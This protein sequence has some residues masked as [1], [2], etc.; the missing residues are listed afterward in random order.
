MTQD[1]LSPK[2]SGRFTRTYDGFWDGTFRV[3]YSN[4]PAWVMYDLLTAK[5][6][7]LG[8]KIETSQVDKWALY[9]VAQYCD[10]MVDNGMGGMEPRF[11]CNAYLTE[12]RQAYEVLQD[13][14]SCFRGMY[15]WD[16]QNVSVN[17][18]RTSDPVAMYTNSNVVE[19][20]FSYSSSP[21]NTISTAVQIQYVDAADGYRTKSEYVSDDV[22][23]KRYGLNVKQIT[24]FGCT[25]RSQAIRTGKWLLETS[26]LERQSV[27]FSVGRAG[28]KHLPYDIIQVVDNDYVGVDMEGRIESVNQYAVTLDREISDITGTEFSYLGTDGNMHRSNIITKVTPTTLRLEEVIVPHANSTF[29]IRSK[30]LGKRFFRAMSISEDKDAGTYTISAI[31]HVPE[32]E[33]IVDNGAVFDPQKNTIYD[34]LPIINGTQIQQDSGGLTIV[35]DGSVVV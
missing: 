15:I 25:S 29:V 35:W 19:G 5:R 33:T 20:I 3:A 11:T 4:N 26:R 17:I 12:N 24:S 14:V 8:R 23:I 30:G 13:L 27:T 1:K 34:R 2:Y 21:L 28:L 18:D 32:K 31:E 6:Y 9:S 16:G 10:Q 7:G 22:A